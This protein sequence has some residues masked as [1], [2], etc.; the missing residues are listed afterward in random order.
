MFKLILLIGLTLSGSHL[1]AQV[2][3]KPP[4]PFGV[5][6]KLAPSDFYVTDISEDIQGNIY[7]V[8]NYHRTVSKYLPDGTLLSSFTDKDFKF[9]RYLSLD[10]NGRIYVLDSG[11]AEV[12]V[13]TNDGIL[14]NTWT[15]KQGAGEIEIDNSDR[16]LL[17]LRGNPAT[18]FRA[19]V[20]VVYD[21]SGMELFNIGSFGSL[22]GNLSI[23]VGV[24]SGL[25]GAIWVT[26]VGNQRIQKF[27]S[28]GVPLFTVGQLGSNPGEFRGPRST[29]VDSM[30]NVFVS[31]RR[32]ER[33]QKFS[34]DGNFLIEW[35]HRGNGPR[36][37]L[38]MEGINVAQDDSLWVAG[39]HAHDIQHFDNEG[40]FLDRWVGHISGPGEF[41]HAKGIGL[42]DNKLFITDHWN[43]EVQVFDSA[44][45]KFLS[46]FGERNQGEA[47]VFNFPRSMEI[48]PQG[49]LYIAD[50]DNIRRIKQDGTFVS[51]FS[52][53]S[54]SRIGSH[55]MAYSTDG[56]LYQSDSGNHRINVIDTA[57]GALLDQWGKKGFIAGE[58]NQP[59]G[60]AIGPDKTV[61]VADNKNYRVQQ[62][63]QD[64][65]FIRSW[66]TIFPPRA[67]SI[68]TIHSIIYVGSWG[69][70]DA[71]DLNGNHLFSWGRL[72]KAPGEFI[73]IYDIEIGSGG[74]VIYTSETDAARVQRF[75][76]PDAFKGKPQFSPGKSLGYYIWKDPDT[77][78]WHVRFSSNSVTHS[79][80]LEVTSTAA[81]SSVAGANLQFNDTLEL[82]TN[83]LLLSGKVSSWQDGVDFTVPESA[84]LKFNLSI[85]NQTADVPVS[86]GAK[87]ITANLT[88]FDY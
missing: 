6:G 68:D 64:G 37:F 41:A 51:M 52:R 78:M 71:Y 36:L 8:D 46:R 35:G 33:I 3:V 22:T 21:L 5:I 12:R 9:P 86:V 40:N 23:P 65:T 28:T 15:G 45:G 32:N 14:L 56:I 47:T 54:G 39:F 44:S 82:Q 20:V 57:T 49:D 10:S 85:D 75:L 48:G 25:D 27:T 24:S 1:Y 81:F 87:A 62:L 4:V 42:V 55:G 29:A 58:F 70:I 17:A 53:P 80:S 74:D 59:R 31:D 67:L 34:P 30:G 7:T 63:T 84:S 50:D 19:D 76:Y 72:G 77:S 60:I 2:P 61:Y 38:E 16:A 66:R 26:E 13:Y 73:G 43:Q 69:K 79:Y 83:T 11:R 88:T 18:N